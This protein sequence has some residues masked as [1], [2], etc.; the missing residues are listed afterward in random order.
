MSLI[1][2]EIGKMRPG[3][4]LVQLA[5]RRQTASIEAQDPRALGTLCEKRG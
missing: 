4:V 3:G 2:A 1:A 5:R